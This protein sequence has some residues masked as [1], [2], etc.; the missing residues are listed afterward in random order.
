MTAFIDWTLDISWWQYPYLVGM[1]VF[2]IH[3]TDRA[4]ENKGND[5]HLELLRHSFAHRVLTTLILIMAS[6]LWPLFLLGA[7]LRPLA[8]RGATMFRMWA[9]RLREYA[10]EDPR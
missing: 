2:L 8:R 10:D 4:R 9:D 1:V 3:E 7:L 5:P 6:P